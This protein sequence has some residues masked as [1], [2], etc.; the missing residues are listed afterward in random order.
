MKKKNIVV[1][2]VTLTVTL[3]IGVTVMYFLV[4]GNKKSFDDYKVSYDNQED[5]DAYLEAIKEPESQMYDV[6]TDT[7]VYQN[8]LYSLEKYNIDSSQFNLDKYIVTTDEL[9]WYQMVSRDNET[10]D[11]Y[12]YYDGTEIKSY[13]IELYVYEGEIEGD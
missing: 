5:V 4:K 3:F 1:F 2:V 12:V 8:L 7:D 9:A 6:S 10:Y 11:I 13:D